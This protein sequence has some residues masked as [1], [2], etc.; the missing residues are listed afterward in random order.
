MSKFKV[1]FTLKQHTPIIHFQSDQSGATL[2]ATE[3]KPKFDRFLKKYAFA[4]K[5]PDELKIDKSKDALNY[6]VKILQDTKE[7]SKYTYK[8]FI[9]KRDRDKV[10][11]RM[12]S[13]F[14]NSKA[15]LSDTVNVTFQVLQNEHKILIEKI[16]EYFADF[17]LITNFGTRQNKGFGSFSVTHID[18]KEEEE[19]IHK[20]FL[21]YYPSY[22]ITQHQEPLKKIMQDYQRLKSGTSKPQY[23]KSLLF[24]YMCS[25]DIR[26]EKRM[27]K[28]YMKKDY[29]NIFSQ[30]KFEKEPIDC[31][32]DKQ[33]NYKYVRGLLGIA[34][35]IEFLK[36]NPKNFKDKIIIKI[37]SKDNI[38][39]FKSPITFK[40]INKDIY[41]LAHN[42]KHIQGK[43]FAFSIKDEKGILNETIEVP[44]NFD[45]FDFLDNAMP[46]LK[47]IVRKAA[48]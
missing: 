1:E 40:V 46:R 41:V 28:E 2:R 12:G 47:Y 38:S 44:Q 9:S 48:S 29:T 42:N 36:R 37:D 23:N 20:V 32:E 5:I 26:W 27:I 25:K 18:G 15:L 24:E 7:P 11:I 21:K 3:L 39:R 31:R 34:D 43:R 19:N 33:F 22:Y 16:R 4:G 35:R 10:D 30:L 8:T 13:Y 17:I 45:I 14:G 6:K